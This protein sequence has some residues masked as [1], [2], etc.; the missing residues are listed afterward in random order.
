M[1]DQCEHLTRKFEQISSSFDGWIRKL[2]NLRDFKTQWHQ[3]IQDA[4]QV[5]TLYLETYQSISLFL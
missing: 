3:F 4:R 5:N 1:F 2:A